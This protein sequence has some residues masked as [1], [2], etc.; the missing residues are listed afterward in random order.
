MAKSVTGVLF[1]HSR[2]E[3]GGP[4]VLAEGDL[5]GKVDEGDVGVEVVG[6]PVRVG[7]ALEGGDL[8]PVRLGTRTDVVGSRCC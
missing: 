8:D 6:V 3:A 7:L 1:S 2:W 4:D 5:L